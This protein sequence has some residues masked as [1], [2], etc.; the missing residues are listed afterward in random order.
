M[1]Q[2]LEDPA[3]LEPS[4]QPLSSLTRVLSQI[5]GLPS[6]VVEGLRQLQD[7]ENS[8][9]EEHQA[10]EGTTNDL[11]EEIF[12]LK[13]NFTASITKFADLRGKEKKE[14]VRWRKN[15]NAEKLHTMK[16]ATNCRKDPEYFNM[17]KD[18]IHEA[19]KFGE[20][21]IKTHNKKKLLEMS[22]FTRLSAQDG[23]V[24]L[25]SRTDYL[26][27]IYRSHW[28]TERSN[29]WAPKP[30][31][32]KFLRME[33]R[34]YWFHH[35]GD[36]HIGTFDRPFA[37][38]SNSLK[39]T[40]CQT[41]SVGGRDPGLAK[42]IF[43]SL[44]AHYSWTINYFASYG[45]L[46][47]LDLHREVA[48]LERLL[49]L[50][51]PFFF[52]LRRIVKL[53]DP[54]AQQ[55]REVRATKKVQKKEEMARQEELALRGKAAK[56]ATSRLK[57]RQCFLEMS[58]RDQGW[59]SLRK[60][61]AGERC[62][63]CEA[64]WSKEENEDEMGL[65]LGLTYKPTAPTSPI[66]CMK[67]EHC[68][69][70]GCGKCSLCKENNQEEMKTTTNC[71]WRRH[72]ARN[73]GV[74]TACKSKEEFGGKGKGKSCEVKG[75]L[76]VQP[77]VKVIEEDIVL[78]HLDEHA[79]NFKGGHSLMS[80]KDIKAAE[81]SYQPGLKGRQAMSRLGESECSQE[82][83]WIR[84][85]DTSWM[86]EATS[87]PTGNVF[88]FIKAQYIC[89]I[90]Q[91]K[92]NNVLMVEKGLQ[93]KTLCKVKNYQVKSHSKGSNKSIK[94]MRKEHLEHMTWHVAKGELWS[95]EKSKQKQAEV[96]CDLCDFSSSFQV[97]L[98]QHRVDAHFPEE[99]MCPFCDKPFENKFL[100]DRHIQKI[101]RVSPPK[102]MGLSSIVDLKCDQ[103]NF[104]TKK[105]LSLRMHKRKHKIN[106]VVQDMEVDESHVT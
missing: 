17:F 59:W 24:E 8:S 106:E 55:E 81:M 98:N 39:A 56:A 1:A 96:F 79:Q 23:E 53:E 44:P 21:S 83:M 45:L 30:T 9:L 41:S 77:E 97:K 63:V 68:T 64:C 22:D 61:K 49:L 20:H 46:Q 19:E 87:L 11:D 82:E 76:V 33:N 47:S 91:K 18:D 70:E 85:V 48:E 74:C 89:T 66:R 73:C 28:S 37:R 78:E 5:D 94:D 92:S 12:S 62:G 34:K 2:E 31:G 101:H 40:E 38:P 99:K 27:G 51:D 3:K 54:Q 36:F 84:L 42:R 52:G 75:E 29:I 32:N 15:G 65:C 43:G 103:C 7:M 80:L 72:C 50:H 102:I 6:K 57:R 16:F 26:R 14:V 71:I 88:N 10:E 100:R 13:S 93:G 58:P 25:E 35:P 67:C 104:T 86:M 4:I 105:E 69:A 95:P 90:C 60:A